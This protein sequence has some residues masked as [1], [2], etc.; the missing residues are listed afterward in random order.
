MEKTFRGPL[1]PGYYDD[2]II[3]PTHTEQ[4]AFYTPLA[5]TFS[6]IRWMCPRPSLHFAAELEVAANLVVGQDAEAVDHGQ[7]PARPFDDLIGVEIEI[8]LVRHR[9]NQR[10]G[11][12]QRGGQ[13][14]L[15]ANVHQTFLIAEEPRPRMARRRVNVLILQLKPVLDIRIV[16]AHLGAHF[17]QLAHD[18]FR[19][20]VPGVAHVLPVAAPQISTS[21]PAM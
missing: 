20:A 16:D 11:M 2:D 19:A 6:L 13:I 9:Q 3:N 15:H 1:A 18:H 4:N 5:R 17:G 8:L 7:R 21:A 14:A 10:L 12:V